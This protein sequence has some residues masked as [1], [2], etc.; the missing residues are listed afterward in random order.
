MPALASETGIR[1]LIKSNDEQV[2]RESYVKSIAL[3]NL[4]ACK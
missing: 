1:R 3:A 2:E 4:R